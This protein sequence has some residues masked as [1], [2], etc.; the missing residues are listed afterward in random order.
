MKEKKN[1]GKKS[2][3]QKFN[4]RKVEKNQREQKTC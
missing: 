4:E 2:Q 1:K 3:K